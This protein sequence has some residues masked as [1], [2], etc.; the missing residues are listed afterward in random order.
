LNSQ[1]GISVASALASIIESTMR[2]AQVTR[3]ERQQQQI[4][5]DLSRGRFARVL[6][7]SREHLAEFPD[8]VDVQLAAELAA[9]E[10]GGEAPG[11]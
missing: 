7:M 9:R 3:R 8:D 6:V 5:I 2:G 4:A 1:R 10:T 11:A